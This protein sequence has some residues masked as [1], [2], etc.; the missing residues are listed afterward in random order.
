MQETAIYNYEEGDN[1]KN[2]VNIRKLDSQSDSLVKC[3]KVHR[4]NLC[5]VIFCL[6]IPCFACY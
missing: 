5:S 1:D 4:G 3:W 2:V 6:S